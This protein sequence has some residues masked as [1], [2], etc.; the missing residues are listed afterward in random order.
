[1]TEPITSQVTFLYFDDIEQAAAF[2]QTI[3]GLELVMDAGWAKIFKTAGQAFIGAVKKG[4]GSIDSKDNSGVLVSLTVADVVQW[5][6]KLEHLIPVSD[7]KEFADI[8]LLSIFL[9]G[10]EGYNF[11]IQEFTRPEQKE[12]F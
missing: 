4:K 11:E 7:V 3:L 10:P 1:M 9:V 8:G 2:F 5:K 12:I 6:E